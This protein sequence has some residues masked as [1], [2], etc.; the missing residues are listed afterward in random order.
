MARPIVTVRDI[1]TTRLITIKAAE[2]V[3][4][5]DIEMQLGHMHHL[6]V[7]DDDNHVVGI[8]SSRDLLRTGGQARVADIMSADVVTI[9]EDQPAHEAAALLIDRQIGALPVLGKT[10]QLVGIVSSTD[11]IEIAYDALISGVMLVPEE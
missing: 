8:V 4:F 7:V 1:M 9:T 6:P 11:F 2:A 5:A 10:G 3:K